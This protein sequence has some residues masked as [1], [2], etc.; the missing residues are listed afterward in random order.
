MTREILATRR[1]EMILLDG[2]QVAKM[3]NLKLKEKIKESSQ[4]KGRNPHLAVILIG[5][6]PASFSYVTGKGKAC[7]LVGIGFTLHHLEKTID[8]KTVE[9]LIISLNKNVAIDGILLQLPLPKQLNEN[10]LIDLIS[11]DKD[12]DGFHVIN[13]G[14]LYQKKEGVVCATPQGIINLL[15]TYEVNPSGM[16]AVIIGRSNIVGFPTARLLM[17][18]GATITVCHSKTKDLSFHTKQAD[19]IIAAAGKPKLITKDMV[20][21]DVIIIDVGVNRVNDHLVG[22][23]DFD[24]LQSVASMMTPVPKGVGPMTI[25]ALLENTYKIFLNH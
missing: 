4:I 16:H 9:D 3:R 20:K 19:L 8:E 25:N 15:K 7:K 11:V 2:Y 12:V 13:Q 1:I 21:K 24:D 14:Y 6:N 5:D 18:L 23:V 17:D 10:R 22:D